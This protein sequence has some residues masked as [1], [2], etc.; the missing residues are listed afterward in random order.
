MSATRYH[1]SELTTC[2][3]AAAITIIKIIQQSILDRGEA[4]LAVSG[5]KSPQALFTRLSQ[6]DLAWEK[7]TITLV[8][9]RYVAPNH[10]DSNEAL[11]H[12]FLLTGRAKAAAFIP[13]WSNAKP[14]EVG[15]K[16][17]ELRLS[18]LNLPFDLILLG[19]G[20]DGHTAS[21]FPASPELT[22]LL[23]LQNRHLCGICHPPQAPHARLTLTAAAVLQSR[24]IILLAAG[25]QKKAVLDLALKEAE[26][27]A[28]M[29][30]RLV[31]HQTHVPVS[32]YSCD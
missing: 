29:P 20:S 14:I 31:L 13:L 6:A 12:K 26:P 2:Y 16:S 22:I 8:D 19:L 18:T 5:G 9:E 28:D 32:I 15:V 27:I 25:A 3:E 30:V 4:L 10:I 11:L 17:A 1:F 24:Q 23:D 21:W 7:V